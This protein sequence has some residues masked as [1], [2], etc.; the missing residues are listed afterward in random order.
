MG[1]RAYIVEFT[2]PKQVADALTHYFSKAAFVLQTS[3][4][5]K[6]SEQIRVRFNFPDGNGTALF[7]RVVSVTPGQGYG[8]QLP[9]GDGL[10]WILRKAKEYAD[11]LGRVAKAGKKTARSRSV[12]S[13][14]NVTRRVDSQELDGGAG[15]PPSGPTTKPIS[16]VPTAPPPVPT[17]R[18]VDT[19]TAEGIEVPPPPPAPGPA[20]QE[21]ARR[22]AQ[23]DQWLVQQQAETLSTSTV[24][25]A[26]PPSPP[27][28]PEEP[29]SSPADA[30]PVDTREQPP[31]SITETIAAMGPNQKKKL[32]ISG[33]EEE[34]RVLVADKDRSVHIWV[35]KNPALTE[36]EVV[37]FAKE[38]TLSTEA[39]MFLIQN[40]RWGT[41]PRVALSLA[42]NPLTPP[43]AIPNLLLVLSEETLK[44][45][46]ST[47]G[48]RHLVARQARRILMERSSF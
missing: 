42:L 15:M 39:L 45:L 41:S 10:D 46:V 12:P 22:V 7:A 21:L 6:L 36:D 27:P 23:L 30:P 1:A 13:D 8:L 4:E 35:L 25:A 29:S 2:E 48:I 16:N 20:E 18:S 9:K 40:R 11:R 3:D 5:L 38:E 26:P 19:N 17:S 37:D 32:A 47:A 43:E 34:R 14:E 44:K 33:T 28:K 24:Q 31:A